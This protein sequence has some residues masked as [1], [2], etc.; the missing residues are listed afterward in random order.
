MAAAAVR[1]V[2]MNLTAIAAS[3]IFGMRNWIQVKWIHARPLTAQMIQVKPI[4]DRA[5]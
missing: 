3:D 5:E 1:F 2:A 4:R